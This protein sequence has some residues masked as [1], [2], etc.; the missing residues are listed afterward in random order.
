MRNLF[1]LYNSFTA[2]EI[3]FFL[4]NCSPIVLFQLLF[5][6][7]TTFLVQSKIS[8]CCSAANSTNF[9]GLGPFFLLSQFRPFFIYLPIDFSFSKIALFLSSSSRPK[10]SRRGGFFIIAPNF[11]D[12]LYCLLR[13]L[14]FEFL[15]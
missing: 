7:N 4:K 15:P 8:G 13:H 3:A 9:K 11:R 10:A 12:Y 14:V 5:L 1:S 2:G 6:M